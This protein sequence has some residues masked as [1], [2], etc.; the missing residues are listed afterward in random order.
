MAAPRRVNLIGEHT[1]YNEGFALPF[2]ISDGVCVAAAARDDGLI[3]VPSRQHGETIVTA[4][5]DGLAPGS[6]SGW[7][8]YPAGVAA[9]NR[10]DAAAGP[11][12]P[13]ARRRWR[14]R[15]SPTQSRPGTSAWP[16]LA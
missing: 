14:T 12:R 16:G 15:P 4:L 5:L 3:A 1:D 10:P 6:P 8:A 2:A 9:A 11:P 13:R 7:P